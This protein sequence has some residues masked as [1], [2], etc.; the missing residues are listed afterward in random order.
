MADDL[1]EVVR[2]AGAGAEPDAPADV[3]LRL[4]VQPGAGRAAV[5]GR[6]GDALRVR[7]APPPADGRANAAVLALLADVLGVPAARL[8]LVAGERTRQKR[9]RIR[10]VRPS[11]IDQ[12]LDE[13]I[14]QAR[15]G[16]GRARAGRP[17]A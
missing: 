5:V 16:P 11:E 13:A 8:E 14:D 6:H 17:G 9:V 3:L 4:S 15:T 2:P 1:F 10:D 7:V 12:R